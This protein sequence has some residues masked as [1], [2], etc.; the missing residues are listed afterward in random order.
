MSDNNIEQHKSSQQAIVELYDIDATNIGGSAYYFT[1]TV[2]STET[3]I[4]WNGQT[5][6][7]FAIASEGWT[8][9][10]DGALPRPKLQI[11][12]VDKI[13][14]AAVISLEDLVGAT[15][16][17]RRIF[18]QFLDGGGSPNPTAL[19]P[20]DDYIINQKVSQTKQMITFELISFLD[21]EGSKIPFRQM[22]RRDF[23]GLAATRIR[24]TN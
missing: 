21:R 1:P 19:F 3:S 13:I 18:E 23:P 15:V 22:L 8:R 11:G 17:R 2:S 7:P 4:I 16:V 12:S 20:V 24:R 10:S 5:Y 14:Q 9:S 6:T